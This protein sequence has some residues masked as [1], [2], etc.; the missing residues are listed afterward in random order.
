M[1]GLCQLTSLL[2]R[3]A[4]PPAPVWRTTPIF[5]ITTRALKRP[6]QSAELFQAAPQCVVSHFMFLKQTQLTGIMR[7]DTDLRF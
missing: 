1:N 4:L 2:S 5:I 7:N 6:F 3:D